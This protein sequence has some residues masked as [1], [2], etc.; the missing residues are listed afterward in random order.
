[1][2]PYFQQLEFIKEKSI[3]FF[4]FNLLAYFVFIAVDI[5]LIRMGLI[6]QQLFKEFG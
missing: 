3:I 6:M 5:Y 4:V 2:N 1:M